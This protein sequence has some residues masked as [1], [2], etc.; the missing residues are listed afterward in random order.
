MN[1]NNTETQN[2]E[3]P[4]TVQFDKNPEKAQYFNE[5]LEFLG[6]SEHFSEL[7]I[8]DVWGILDTMPRDERLKKAKKQLKRKAV[9]Q[10]AFKPTGLKKPPNRMN[11]F[12]E[13]F[14]QE[15]K[16]EDRKYTK[17]YF[18]AAYKALTEE[19]LAELDEECSALKEIYEKRYALLKLKAIH[20]G[21]YPLDTVKRACSSYMMF[22]KAC[23]A[24]DASLLS[25][26]QISALKKADGSDF[27]KMIGVIKGIWD[28]LKHEEKQRFNDIA[29][30]DKLRY[31]FQVYEHDV[32]TLEAQIRLAQSKGET[33]RVSELESELADLRDNEPEEYED[34]TSSDG[35][36]PLYDFS[37]LEGEDL[38][39]ESS[40]TKKPTRKA[41]KATKTPRKSKKKV[42]S[43]DDDEE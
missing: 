18:E 39:Q 22:S 32:I 21:E 34:Y 33:I 31:K 12:R 42:E 41:A 8:D 26:P 43:D 23:H 24:K 38:T 29:A 20:D 2:M 40:T 5:L 3:C 19:A 37:V 9:K 15:C 6:T 4:Y 27:K 14:K 13:K 16:E 28:K 25:K 7:E 1:T 17:E 36:A 10:A 11:L 30:N 35:Y